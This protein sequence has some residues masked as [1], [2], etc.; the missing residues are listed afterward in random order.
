MSE[1]SPTKMATS[2]LTRVTDVS[3]RVASVFI[4]ALIGCEPRVSVLPSKSYSLSIDDVDDAPVR[5]R[6]VD[7]RPAV[8]FQPPGYP[9]ARVLVEVA[10][11]RAAIDRG[12]QHRHHLPADHG[13]LFLMG[14]EDI[15]TFWM[16]NTSIPLDIIFIA[17]DMRVVGVVADAVPHTDVDRMVP[18]RSLYVV[19]VN[20]GFASVYHVRA[21]TPL[22]FEHVQP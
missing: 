3:W 16:R 18:A 6:Q 4:V 15:H 5:G 2:S 14:T 10:R 22:R 12:L 19:E 21:G 17:A 9:S 13:M 20:A 7:R 11:T 8:V 1:M